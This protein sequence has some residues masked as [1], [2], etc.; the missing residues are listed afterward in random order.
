MINVVIQVNLVGGYYGTGDNVKL[1]TLETAVTLAASSIVF[2]DSDPAYSSKLLQ[3][4]INVFNFANRYRGSYC[5]SL[6][7]VICPFYCSYS[8]YHV[9]MMMVSPSAGMTSDPELKSSFPRLGRFNGGLDLKN[10]G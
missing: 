5:D 8:G 9:L 10:I 7:S 1:K 4:A 6:G 2:G 3:A